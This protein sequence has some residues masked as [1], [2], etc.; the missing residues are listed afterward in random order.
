MSFEAYI[1]PKTWAYYSEEINPEE[2]ERRCLQPF[3]N[4]CFELLFSGDSVAADSREWSEDIITCLV[5]ELVKYKTLRDTFLR[6]KR[7]AA[8]YRAVC[9]M[10]TSDSDR[11][12]ELEWW[13]ATFLERRADRLVGGED[14]VL[15]VDDI[16]LPRKG[17][18]SVWVAPQYAS[19]LGKTVNCQ[20]LVSLRLARREASIMVGLRLPEDRQNFR[21]KQEIAIEEIDR[22]IAS[23]VRF[24]CVLADAEYGLSASF[25]Q[26]L[27]A[28]GLR[29]AVGIP[30]QLKLYPVDAALFSPVAGRG[31]PRWQYIPDKE[32]V[33][34]ETMLAGATWRSLNWRRGTKGRLSASFAA[35]RVRIADGSP[36]RIGE[37][38][39][40]IGERHNN[41]KQKYYLANLP[42]NMKIRILAS[43]VKA[44]CVCKQAHQK[45]EEA[46]GLDHFKG[47]S[48]NGLHRHALMRMIA[49]AFLQSH[50]LR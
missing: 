44:R 23:G 49:Y 15:V 24:G 30:Q 33:A 35:L 32:S 5:G 41:G 10:A 2:K 3:E 4:I 22:L 19:A 42:A 14:A 16:A 45:M 39:W 18:H 11:T 21:S 12:A 43:I 29:W 17:R 34:A 28:R 48:W 31:R 7:L 50:R 20:T 26:A 37:E 46:L 38:V 9:L 13:L 25:R 40:L 6:E 27:C 47:S 8:F 1:N 36:Q